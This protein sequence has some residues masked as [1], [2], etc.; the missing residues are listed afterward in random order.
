MIKYSV[1]LPGLLRLWGVKNIFI[2]LPVVCTKFVIIIIYIHMQAFK[3]LSVIQ[4]SNLTS[5]IENS[6]AARTLN[7][8]DRFL[9]TRTY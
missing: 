2:S 7:S 9:N 4:N 5:T 8:T 1:M 3:A 6:A